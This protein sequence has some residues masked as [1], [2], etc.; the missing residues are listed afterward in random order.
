MHILFFIPLLCCALAAKDPQIDIKESLPAA[1]VIKITPHTAS[2]QITLLKNDNPDIENVVG[3][4][5]IVLKE[6]NG[7]VSEQHAV[8]KIRYADGAEDEHETF[9]A[10][11]EAKDG[12]QYHFSLKT[13]QNSEDE[14]SVRGVAQISEACG[15]VEYQVPEGQKV[16][17][18]KKTLFPMQHLKLLLTQALNGQRTNSSIVFDGS[19]ESFVPIDV[20]SAIQPVTPKLNIKGN[21]EVD[22][23]KAYLMQM[24]VYEQSDKDMDPVYITSQVVQK[25]GI[26]ISMD[27]D[28]PEIGFT[29]RAQLVKVDL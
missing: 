14:T 11:W 18:P 20:E 17:L 9:L 4:L 24:A 22:F 15:N 10:S 6:S 16:A 25:D 21:C 26:I 8:L 1:E 3:T 12:G 13:R 19:N 7:I 23:K 28:F 27:M 29:T 2:Y 5:V